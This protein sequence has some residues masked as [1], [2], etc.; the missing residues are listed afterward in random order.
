MSSNTGHYSLEILGQNM[1]TA[2][3]KGP[4]LGRP[5]PCQ[6]GARTQPHKKMPAGAGIVQKV[7]KVIQRGI[8]DVNLTKEADRKKAGILPALSLAQAKTLIDA[9]RDT[10]N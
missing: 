9:K 10:Q 1:V 5:H 4:G 6:T 3:D 8:G 2:A 7:L